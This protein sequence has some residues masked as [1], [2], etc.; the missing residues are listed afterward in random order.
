MAGGGRWHPAISGVVEAARF[1]AMATRGRII[2][3]QGNGVSLLR[4]IVRGAHGKMASK[5]AWPGNLKHSPTSGEDREAGLGGA[6]RG[7]ET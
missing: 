2:A 3:G 7:Q 4:I 1:A 6:A 5:R